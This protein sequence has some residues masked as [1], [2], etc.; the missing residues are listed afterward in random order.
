MDAWMNEPMMDG[1]MNGWWVS[2]W[3]VGYM[4]VCV[5]AC[6]YGGMDGYVHE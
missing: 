6:M 5:C 3:K 2:G 4:H 1:W